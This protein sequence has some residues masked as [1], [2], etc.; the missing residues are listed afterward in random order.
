MAPYGT[1]A[2]RGQRRNAGMPAVWNGDVQAAKTPFFR[3]S[4]IPHM[5]GVFF[6]LDEIGI[7]SA[8]VG[9]ELQAGKVVTFKTC[10]RR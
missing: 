4:L 5:R 2:V 7:I 8:C 3:I 9:E 1:K 10:R 6:T